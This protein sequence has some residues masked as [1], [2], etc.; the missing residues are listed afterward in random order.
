MILFTSIASL[1]IMTLAVGWLARG[2]LEHR[3]HQRNIDALRKLDADPATAW[4]PAALRTIA[5][6]L[7]RGETP[8][9]LVLSCATRDGEISYGLGPGE[10]LPGRFIAVEVKLDGGQPAW[11][12]EEHAAPDNIRD[13]SGDCG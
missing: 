1:W 7:Q 12:F 2:E 3:R 8:V 13:I 9:N 6:H 11:I 4:L 5:G 10:P